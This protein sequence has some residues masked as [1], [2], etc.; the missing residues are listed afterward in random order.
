MDWEA[1]RERNPELYRIAHNRQTEAAFSGKYVD[2][3]DIGIYHCAVCGAPLFSS[4]AKFNVGSGW[5]SFT[6]PINL[7]AVRLEKEH[8]YGSWNFEIECLHC[9]AYL[10][11]RFHD[12]PLRDGKISYRYSINSISLILKKH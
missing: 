5:A 9:G 4:E 10:G 3:N 12:G 2:T 1:L 11:R 8:E 6:Q 7:K